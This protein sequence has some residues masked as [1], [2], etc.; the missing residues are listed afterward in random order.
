M[1]CTK[2]LTFWTA[3]AGLAIVM[4]FVNLNRSS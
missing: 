1:T 3:I 2:C 4:I